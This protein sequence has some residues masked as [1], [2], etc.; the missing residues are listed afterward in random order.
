MSSPTPINKRSAKAG[1]AVRLSTKGDKTRGTSRLRGSARKGPRALG[2]PT[3]PRF[4]QVRAVIGPGGRVVI[5][6]A[7]RQA[8]G[9]KEGDA[10]FIRLDG[11]GL[12]VVSDDTE[13]FEV[14]EMLARYVPAGT[15]LVDELIE[16]RRREAAA[17]AGGDA[18][19]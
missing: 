11:D 6:A 5:P 8:L 14:R 15:S 9:I 13:V 17:D 3:D 16:E 2:Q 4:E 7:Y 19:E 12:R 1:S 10:V 18:D